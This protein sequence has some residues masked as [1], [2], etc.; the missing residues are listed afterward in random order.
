M[1]RILVVCMGN[2]CRSPIASGVLQSRLKQAPWAGQLEVDSAGTYAGHAGEPA[3][4]RAI[5]VCLA[6]GHEAVLNERARR[7]SD[8][9]FEHF[10]LILAMDRGN[11][12]H[13]EDACPAPHRHKLHLFLAYAGVKEATEV[14]DPYYG[15]TE[16][17][18][19]VLRL[20]EA[21]ADGVLRRLQA[22]GL[23]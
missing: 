19:R 1:I 11:L 18:E 17:F 9:D 20:C 16:G 13:L 5:A 15:G 23:V 14:P 6:A 8:E 4:P 2:I 3:D 21:G 12:M 22:E 10:D 7:I